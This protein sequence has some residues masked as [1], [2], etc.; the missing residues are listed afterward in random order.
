MRT[1]SQQDFG[2]QFNAD[3]RSLGDL[4][5]IAKR[6]ELAESLRNKKEKCENVNFVFKGP[7]KQERPRERQRGL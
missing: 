6:A 1:G 3:P 2:R 7:R 4:C 5:D